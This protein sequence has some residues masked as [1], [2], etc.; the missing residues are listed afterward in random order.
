MIG[1]G[2]LTM[3]I[4]GEIPDRGMLVK[5]LISRDSAMK[6]KRMVLLFDLLATPVMFTMILLISQNIGLRDDLVLVVAVIIYPMW[7]LEYLAIQHI[8]SINLYS[9]FLYSQGI[10]Y[11]RSLV[12]KMLSRSKF[13]PKADI[14]EIRVDR[15]GQRVQNPDSDVSSFIIKT[16]NGKTKFSG[17]RETNDVRE[18]SEYIE[19]QWSIKVS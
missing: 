14:I 7:I 10:Q 8:F 11:P 13:V 1:S 19:K 17:S 9:I 12:D 18:A 4:M 2:H 5:E 16:R 15:R 3:I 6:G